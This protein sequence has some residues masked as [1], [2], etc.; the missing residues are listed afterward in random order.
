MNKTYNLAPC[1]RCNTQSGELIE[2]IAEGRGLYFCKCSKCGVMTIGR[3]YTGHPTEAERDELRTL[4][5][6]HWQ[7]GDTIN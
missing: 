4:A 2:R 3:A 5:V 6:N 7:H 1:T